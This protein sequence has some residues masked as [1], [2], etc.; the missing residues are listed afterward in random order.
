MQ[1]MTD[2]AENL[3]EE[4]RRDDNKIHS[5]PQSHMIHLQQ[6]YKISQKKS[7]ATDTVV[8]VLL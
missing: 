3:P 4:R 1:D 6:G 8:R 2:L 5:P 7:A